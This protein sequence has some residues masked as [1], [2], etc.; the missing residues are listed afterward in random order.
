MTKNVPSTATPSCTS[1]ALRP[2][3]VDSHT[4]WS[5]Y[6]TPLFLNSSDS[7]GCGG[8]TT[9][10]PRGGATT[11]N[12]ARYREPPKHQVRAQSSTHGPP[13][14]GL[15]LVPPSSRHTRFATAESPRPSRTA[16]LLHGLRREHA[17]D[18]WHPCSTADVQDAAGC[19]ACNGVVVRCLPPHLRPGS[20]HVGCGWR[21]RPM[22]GLRD[23]CQPHYLQ[24]AEAAKSF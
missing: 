12:C 17:E 20:G 5:D 2:R 16:H 23:R 10:S 1:T 15:P 9:V 18:G 7:E 6:S 19:A 8:C 14:V 4:P 22:A 11:K 24:T 21:L 13:L 3:P